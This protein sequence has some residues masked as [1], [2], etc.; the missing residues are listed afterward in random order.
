MR[1]YEEREID[2]VRRN[3]PGADSVR[4]RQRFAHGRDVNTRGAIG[5]NGTFEKERSESG[6]KCIEPR[7]M[8]AAREWYIHAR[9]LAER[10]RNR[11]KGWM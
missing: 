5:R 6:R 1:K 4:A 2:G 9:A 10:S 11:E 8:D 3:G 7:K